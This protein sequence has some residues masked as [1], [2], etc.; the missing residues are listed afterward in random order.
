MWF[1]FMIPNPHAMSLGSHDVLVEVW[2]AD[3]D[4]I[5]DSSY[6]FDTGTFLIDFEEMRQYIIWEIDQFILSIQESPDELWGDPVEQRK[7]AMTNKLNALKE[8]VLSDV[9]EAAYSKLLHDI[10]PLLTGLKTDENNMDWGNGILK[11][12]WVIFRGF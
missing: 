3:N 6:N 12:A 7:D 10:K 11:N 8:L 5:G 2:D 1:D 4:R 9:F